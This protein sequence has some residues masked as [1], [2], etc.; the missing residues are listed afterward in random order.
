MP[1]DVQVVQP[2]AD[3]LGWRA[4]LPDDLKQ[5]EAFVPFKTVG[6]FAKSD[7]ELRTKTADLE[8][9]LG[10]SIPKLKDDA[11]DV[12]RSA[13]YDAL[14]RPKTANEYE[15]DGEDKNATE[16]TSQWKQQFHSIGLTKPQAKALSTAWNASVQKMVE[17]HNASLKNEITA[18]DTKLRSEYGDKYDTNVELAKRLFQKHIGTE[19][20]KSFDAGTS[21]IRSDTIRLLVKLASLTG[22]DRSPQGGN[23]QGGGSKG[24]TFIDYSVKGPMPPP[25]R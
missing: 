17:A 18:L 13:Y 7:L 21:V 12:E 24:T 15:I 22:E 5:N 2:S 8:G 14:G 9:K 16:W 20:D 25:K 10:N 4:G 19:F 1:E 23:S 11:T 6:D 3:S